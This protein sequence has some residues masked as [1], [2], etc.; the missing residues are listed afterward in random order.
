M[1]NF[2]QQQPYLPYDGQPQPN[3]TPGYS[4]TIQTTYGTY[5]SQVQS[6]NV[7]MQFPNYPNLPPQQQPMY[8]Q[9]QQQYNQQPQQNQQYTN[10]AYPQGM[11]PIPQTIQN[12]MDYSP[13]QQVNLTEQGIPSVA[14]G[15]N[16]NFTGY[17]PQGE[18]HYQNNNGQFD[19]GNPNN[20]PYADQ[21]MTDNINQPMN[22]QAGEQYDQSLYNDG[23]GVSFNTAAYAN[24][25]LNNGIIDP[26][27]YSGQFNPQFPEPV[28]E[29]D[30]QYMQ[31]QQQYPQYPQMQQQ[32][33][34]QQP[35]QPN[36]VISTYPQQIPQQLQQP[37]MPQFEYVNNNLPQFKLE[38]LVEYRN[39]TIKDMAE[40]RIV[41]REVIKS[42]VP[43]TVMDKDYIQFLVNMSK[44]T[45]MMDNGG[46]DQEYIQQIFDN[47]T[48][49]IVEINGERL[50]FSYCDDHKYGLSM[51][52][53][54]LIQTKHTDGSRLDTYFEAFKKYEMFDMIILNLMQNF[55]DILTI[56]A[57]LPDYLS[58]KKII[59]DKKDGKPTFIPT[60]LTKLL[61]SVGFKHAGLLRNA[62]RK[63]NRNCSVDIY[64]LNV[65]DWYFKYV[66]KQNNKPEPTLTNTDN[67]GC[68]T[69][70]DLFSG[71]DETYTQFELDILEEC[72]E[73]M[74]TKREELKW[75][76]DPANP[77][78][79]SDN[80]L[81]NFIVGYNLDP[82]FTE[83][84]LPSRT[85]LISM[86]QNFYND[87][88]MKRF[89]STKQDVLEKLKKYPEYYSEGRYKKPKSRAKTII[90]K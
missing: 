37:V 74:F 40:D 53:H 54:G 69:E 87:E 8:G 60:E 57:Y 22:F 68:D 52:L 83:E 19:A 45:V 28:A 80:E 2:N 4:K 10:N 46:W 5:P 49:R 21:P 63:N 76:L 70:C 24:A 11:I 33:Q 20:Y 1:S 73:F 61:E 48:T 36:Q 30:P 56:N 34:P 50:G 78:A 82:E 66:E 81:Y 43:F 18:F 89:D 59:D 9:P 6:Q 71:E 14:D 77:D 72:K 85:I 47:P 79:Y 29:F 7:Q 62:C 55:N 31:P 84:N 88:T 67:T 44:D 23:N 27:A 17:I 12:G 39:A 35:L 15:Y 58:T 90:K 75:I 41:V 51:D 64:Q 3:Q 38:D 13:Q 42:H 25:P 86:I 32:Y 65:N 26:K 16:Q